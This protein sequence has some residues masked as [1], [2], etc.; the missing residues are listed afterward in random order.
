MMNN[1]K[2]PT[3]NTPFVL[4]T[5]LVILISACAVESYSIIEP[6]RQTLVE[7]PP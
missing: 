7:T 5:V 6:A 2:T 1:V 4:L 3:M